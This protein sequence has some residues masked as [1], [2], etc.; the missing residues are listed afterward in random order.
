MI[1][2]AT[3]QQQVAQFLQQR[4]HRETRVLGQEYLIADGAVVGI[5]SIFPKASA[6][7]LF[8]EF[9]VRID[10]PNGRVLMTIESAE[11]KKAA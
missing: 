1:H 7:W 6:I 9:N 11:A 10:D 3:V 5:R 8:E 4:G 2:V